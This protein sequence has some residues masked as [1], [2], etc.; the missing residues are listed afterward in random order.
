[1]PALDAQSRIPLYHQL[2]D[3]LSEEIR[4]GTYRTGD[5]IP[6]EPE[7]ARRFGIGR[8]TVRQATDRLVKRG[9]LERRRGSGT[10][11]TEPPEEVDLFSLAGTLASFEKKGIP[12]KTRMLTRPRRE[13]VDAESES[14]FAG[15][16]AYTFSRLSLVSGEPVLL[17]EL[18]LDPDRFRGL[19][20]ISLAGRSLAQLVDEHFHLRPSSA[21]QNFRIATLDAERAARLEQPEG[22]PILLVHRRLHFPGAREALFAALYCRTDRMLFSQSLNAPA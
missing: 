8:P 22:S 13:P 15:R 20:H 9:R 2:A 17:E 7:L 18:Q 12:V 19:E 21:E 5:R 4:R 6:S 11:V 14:P 10:F 16:E 1:M 3:H